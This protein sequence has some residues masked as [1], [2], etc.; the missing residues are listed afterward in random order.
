MKYLVSILLYLIGLPTFLI[1]AIVVIV[2]SFLFKPQQYDRFVKALCRILLRTFFIKVDVIGMERIDPTKTYIFMSNHVNIF[3][4]FVLYGYIPNFARGVELDSHFR[5]PIWGKVITRFGNIPISHKKLRGA[6][7]SLNKAEQ[8]IQNG[9]S[10]IILPEGHRTRD[11]KL[12]PFMRG[13]FLM[14]QK[15]RTD[16][17]ATAMVGAYNIKRVSHWLIK[18]GTVKFVIGDVIR[19]ESFKTLSTH[20]LKE[21]VKESIQ[22]LLDEN[23]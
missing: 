16:I 11:G 10:I 7:N 14:A 5:W 4:V 12:L 20:E 17:V 18:P 19:Y 15:A 6:L 9:T 22:K 2:C 8:A 13:P 21:T 23:H 3:D 1:V